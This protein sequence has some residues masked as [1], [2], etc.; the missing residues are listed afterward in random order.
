MMN[1]LCKEE[2]K[3]IYITVIVIMENGLSGRKLLSA[4][5]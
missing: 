5:E 4:K 2:K 3:K 1:I